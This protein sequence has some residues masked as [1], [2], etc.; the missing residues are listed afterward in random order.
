M[1]GCFR[2]YGYIGISLIALAEAFILLKASSLAIWVTPLC[3]TGY[4]LLVDALVFRLKGGS[5]ISDRTAEFFVMLPLSAGIWAVFEWYN[6][7]IRNWHY[8]NLPANLWV[9]YTGYIWSFS[10]IMP[11]IFETADLLG[12]LGLSASSS[13]M[14]IR[15]PLLFP[16]MA[17]GA[18]FLILPLVSSPK[19]ASYMAALVWTGFIFLLDPMNY[20]LGGESILGDWERGDWSRFWTLFAGGAICGVLWEF[21][22]FWAGAKWRYTV[23]I[24]GDVKIFEMPVLG[25]LGFPAFALELFDIYSFIRLVAT[26]AGKVQCSRSKVQGR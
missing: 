7:F 11:A 12:A 16:L 4:I 8:I 13:G 20:L 24:L 22:N 9:R 18:A 23:P 10:T 19:A 26:R 17:C 25:Y 2:F 1:R 14:R 21:W 6:L 5:L 15:R 3:W